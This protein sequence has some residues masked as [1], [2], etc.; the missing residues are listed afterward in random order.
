MGYRRKKDGLPIHG[1]RVT[2]TEG[3]GRAQP[4]EVVVQLKMGPKEDRVLVYAYRSIKDA[5]LKPEVLGHYPPTD[6]PAAPFPGSIPSVSTR[7]RIA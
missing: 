3:A 6:R 1:V 4:S 5:K 2:S 7:T